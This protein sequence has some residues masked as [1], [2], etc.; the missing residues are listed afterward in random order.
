MIGG[1]ISP[2]DDENIEPNNDMIAPSCG[3]IAAKMTAKKKNKSK[4]N[5]FKRQTSILND[6]S[7]FIFLQ[8]IMIKLIRKIPS[9]RP[10]WL[11]EKNV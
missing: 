10:R 6:F 3:T 5:E 2:S 8:V 1:K 9:L 7:E 4:F 11:S